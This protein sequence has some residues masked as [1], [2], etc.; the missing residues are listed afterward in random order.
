MSVASKLS[1]ALTNWYAYDDNSVF[2]PRNGGQFT[3][4]LGAT[5]DNV[6]RITSLPMRAE[7]ESVTG[8]GTSLDLHF[9]W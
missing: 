9:H 5:Q 8:N 4:N 6:T 3:I 7:L 1:K 2:I